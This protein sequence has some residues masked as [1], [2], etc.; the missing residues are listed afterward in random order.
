MAV[1]ACSVYQVS[2]RCLLGGAGQD[3]G[4]VFHVRG[5][6]GRGKPLSGWAPG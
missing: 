6:V 1:F 2:G 3:F 5:S 4:R